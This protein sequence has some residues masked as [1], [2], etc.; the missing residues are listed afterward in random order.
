MFT[1]TVTESW[2]MGFR[3]SFLLAK[4]VGQVTQSVSD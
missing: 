2:S 3:F 1:N 4:D